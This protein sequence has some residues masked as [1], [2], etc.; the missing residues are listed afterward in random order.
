MLK[1]QYMW[2]R[3]LSASLRIYLSPTLN[4]NSVNFFLFANKQLLHFT[5]KLISSQRGTKRLIERSCSGNV[6]SKHYK[7]G[8]VYYCQK[9]YNRKNVS[10]TNKVWIV[11]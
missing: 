4:F 6:P 7:E 8:K 5:P 11:F 9:L 3:S 2:Q 1:L 10:Q